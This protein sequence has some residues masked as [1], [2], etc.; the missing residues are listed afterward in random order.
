MI[1]LSPGSASA[2]PARGSV[3]SA[4]GAVRRYLAK[5][6]P[7]VQALSIALT[8]IAAYL[9]FGKIEGHVTFD[10][11]AVAAALLVVLMFLQYRLVDDVC[12]YC[13]E[14]LGGPGVIPGRPRPMIAG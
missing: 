8:P 14:E 2:A 12:T 1:D 10:G 3:L 5:Q 4:A 9:A 7:L 13:N 6:F 11:P